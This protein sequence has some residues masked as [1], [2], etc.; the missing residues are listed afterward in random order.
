MSD[1]QPTWWEASL[2]DRER[3]GMVVQPVVERLAL[4]RDRGRFPHAVL[5]VGPVGLGRELAGIETAVMLTCPAGGE[6]WCQCPSCQRVRKGIHPDVDLLLPQGAAR[7]INIEQIRGVV[8]AA[9]GR[10]FEAS[11]RIWILDGVEAGRL[12]I[13]A[14]N[15]FLK[16]LEEPPDHVRFVLLA[17]NPNAVL[18]TIRSRCQRLMLPGVV[19]I[20]EHLDHRDGPPELAAQ[21]LAGVAVS[22]TMDQVTQALTTAASGEVLALLGLAHDLA[23]EESGFS[24]IAAGAL[25]V[26]REQQS[27]DG[28]DLVRLAAALLA[29]EHRTRLLN[30]NRERQ[31]LAC[32]LTWYTRLRRN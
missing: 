31:I 13:E 4:A 25:A 16:V 28:E 18:P 17:G 20:A 10:P 24:V 11:R 12:G 9:P 5:L 22:K 15:A 29:A 1:T 7:K 27:A 19:A 30:L 3:W 26:V 21:A 2:L 14:G 8:R 23:D 32:L 6:P